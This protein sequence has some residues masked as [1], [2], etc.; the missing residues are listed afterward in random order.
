MKTSLKQQRDELLVTLSELS[1]SCPFHQS[2]PE[3]CPLFPLRKIKSAKRLH[4]LKA[5][6]EEDLSYLA[7]YHHICLRIKV[8]SRGAASERAER[9][10]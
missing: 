1:K 4:W 7:T 9:A 5:L 2:N 3:D 10:L 6:S 8:E